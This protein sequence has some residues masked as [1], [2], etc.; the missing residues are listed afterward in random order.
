[1]FETSE[2]IRR[3]RVSTK[4]SSLIVLSQINRFQNLNRYSTSVRRQLATGQN[5]IIG[6]D[7]EAARIVLKSP[8]VQPQTKRIVHLHEL[9]SKEDYSESVGGT[10]SVKYV[11]KN[12]DK[13]DAVIV[14]DT[15]RAEYIQSMAKLKTPPL[16]V[17]NCPRRLLKLPESSLLPLLQKRGIYSCTIVHYQGSIG[18]DH[19]LETVIKSMRLWPKDSILVIVGEAHQDYLKQLDTL[20]QI[21][22]VAGRVIFVGRVAYSQLFNYAAGASVGITLLQPTTRNWELSA[23][24][25]NKRF[26]YAALGIPQVTNNG[27]GINELFGRTG[28]AEI[29]DQNDVVDVGRK[30]SQYLTNE[31]RRRE[32]GAQGRRFHL[33]SYNY[34]QQ[35][36]KVLDLLG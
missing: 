20:I 34:E 5:A 19:C 7:P 12:L 9:P 3:I 28:I 36:Q 8:S 29:A 2:T 11:V 18:P 15:Y 21:E 14:P 10:L 31:S 30:I 33:Q 32:A 13:A 4:D 26:E 24:A 17:M 22:K 16:V 23:G 6:F 27:P 35:F 1:M 25:S